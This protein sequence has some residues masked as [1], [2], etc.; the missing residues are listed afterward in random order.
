MRLDYADDLMSAEADDELQAAIEESSRVTV[1]RAGRS[2]YG[3][4]KMSL[5][6]AAAREGNRTNDQGRR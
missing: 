3:T 1:L 4:N 5:P 6:A 2:E